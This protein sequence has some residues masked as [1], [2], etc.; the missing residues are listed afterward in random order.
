MA[1]LQSQ[2]DIL[3]KAIVREHIKRVDDKT[4]MVA[5][6][7]KML[8][9]QYDNNYTTS[10]TSTADG[11]IITTTTTTTLSLQTKPYVQSHLSAALVNRNIKTGDVNKVG[12]YQEA[13][14]EGET[15]QRLLSTTITDNASEKIKFHIEDDDEHHVDGFMVIDDDRL[16]IEDESIKYDFQHIEG[17]Q[18]IN[19]SITKT[20][21][22]IESTEEITPTSENSHGNI[23][24]IIDSKG[25]IIANTS[26]KTS[27]STDGEGTTTHKV[28]DVTF[29]KTIKGGMY[30][31]ANLNSDYSE[32]LQHEVNFIN[33]GPS[34]LKTTTDPDQGQGG[35]VVQG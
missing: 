3:G 21:K 34:T 6:N 17:E 33:I 32:G 16:S 29:D 10:T 5:I 4:E 12:V 30:R 28:Q 14:V 22:Y 27:I 9:S 8:Q 7:D 31:L 2:I 19:A 24:Y 13:K 23:I 20:L 35:E 11:D 25:N 15:A 26:T 18:T 1:N